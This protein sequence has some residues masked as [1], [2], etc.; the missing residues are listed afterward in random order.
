MNFMFLAVFGRAINQLYFLEF[1]ASDKNGIKH[2]YECET[3]LS[4]PDAR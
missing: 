4:Q 3:G 1:F 2:K